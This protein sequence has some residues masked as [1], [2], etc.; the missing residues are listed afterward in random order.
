M[1]MKQSEM[2]MGLEKKNPA[3]QDCKNHEHEAKRN[4]NWTCKQT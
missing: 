2:R 4:A 3:K 1:S